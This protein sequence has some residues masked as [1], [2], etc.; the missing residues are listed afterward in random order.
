MRMIC[1][2]PR[3]SLRSIFL[4]VAPIAPLAKPAEA[5][6]PCKGELHDAA[7][8]KGKPDPTTKGKDHDYEILEQNV[9]QQRSTEPTKARSITAGY[10][11]VVA[12]FP[13]RRQING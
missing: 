8:W 5:S 3:A 6:N 10:R 7:T 12:L 13:E 4:G 9:P 11:Q 1:T 2:I